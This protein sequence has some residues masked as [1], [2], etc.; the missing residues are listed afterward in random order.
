MSSRCLVITRHG[1]MKEFAD[2]SYAW[3]ADPFAVAIETYL[4]DHI[5]RYGVKYPLFRYQFVNAQGEPCQP[6][7]GMWKII[8]VGDGYFGSSQRS[9]G[10]LWAGFNAYAYQDPLGEIRHLGIE[11][12]KAGFQKLLYLSR[13][14][15]WMEV[16]QQETIDGLQQENERLKS[17]IVELQS[18]AASGA[19]T[20]NPS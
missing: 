4:R 2:L 5:S 3:Q 20:P 11:D 6:S 18:P 9:D 15:N 19:E 7:L 10:I 12:L 1:E 8:K 16:S 13:F 14:H 17:T